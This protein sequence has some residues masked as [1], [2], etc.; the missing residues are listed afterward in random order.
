[1]HTSYKKAFEFRN[2]ANK[3]LKEHKDE[4]K[5][6]TAIEDVLEQFEDVDAKFAKHSNRIRRKHAAED[7]K[8]TTIL[9]EENGA[10]K[11]TKEGEEKVEDELEEMIEEERDLDI[12][13]VFVEVPEGFPRQLVK[14]FKGFVFEPDANPARD[15]TKKLKDL[16]S[17]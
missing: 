15:L 13:P 9:R 7:P 3:F 4:T 6:K 5:L 12:E 10:Y 2:A 17:K 11:Y 8:N 1:M 14:Y 16:T